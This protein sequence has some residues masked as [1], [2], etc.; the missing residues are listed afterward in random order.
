M[1]LPDTDDF[2]TLGGPLNEYSP[3]ED[4]T[5]DLPG[6]ADNAARGNVAA[7]TRVL[8]RGYVAFVWNGSTITIV[9]RDAVW[10]NDPSLDPVIVHAGTGVFTLTFPV[11]VPYVDGSGTANVNLRR[12]LAIV[13]AFGIFIFPVMLAANEIAISCTNSS[14]AFTDPTN[15]TIV[16]WYR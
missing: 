12:A 8:F 15:K 6:A 9:D 5:T 10:G 13:E 2:D 14:S 16:V 1:P 11:T 4:A 7:T 3:V